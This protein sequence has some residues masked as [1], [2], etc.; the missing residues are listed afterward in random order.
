MCPELAMGASYLDD[1]FPCDVS[2]QEI[3]GN[4]FTV[5]MSIH[6][7]LD[8]PRHLVG[9]QVVKILPGET[10]EE[11]QSKSSSLWLTFKEQLSHGGGTSFLS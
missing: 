10:K 7:V 9:I 2:H 4:V 8:V 5:H 1:S 6:P 11:T 3:H